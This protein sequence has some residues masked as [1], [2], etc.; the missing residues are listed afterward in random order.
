MHPAS[1]LAISAAVMLTSAIPATSDAGTLPECDTVRGDYE[2][3][4]FEACARALWR[5]MPP[6]VNDITIGR[7]KPAPTINLRTASRRVTGTLPSSSRIFCSLIALSSDQHI[8]ICVKSDSRFG[9]DAK[10]HCQDLPSKGDSNWP[11]ISARAAVRRREPWRFP[12]NSWWQA[13]A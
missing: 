3:V 9:A 1:L 12:E 4:A 6:I 7:E 5:G 2:L 11:R 8:L 13:R 10:R